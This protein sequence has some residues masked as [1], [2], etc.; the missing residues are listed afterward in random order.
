MP[1]RTY[2]PVPRFTPQPLCIAVTAVPGK[3]GTTTFFM[4]HGTYSISIEL[5]IRRVYILPVTSLGANT[6]LWAVM[7]N[8]HLGT[9]HVPNNR[10][11]HICALT[12]GVPLT[13]D[14][15]HNQK[16]TIEECNFLAGVRNQNPH[17]LW[18]PR[19]L[20][21][22]CRRFQQ[23]RTSSFLCS[24]LHF[25]HSHHN[26]F[27]PYLLW[28]SWGYI[29]TPGMPGLRKPILY[30]VTPTCQQYWGLSPV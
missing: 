6:F 7:K 27:A 17:Q 14:H 11:R 19:R 26:P 25:T 3:A 13:H 15:L 23:L 20:C 2:S 5:I 28:G 30:P 29:R 10:G 12:D 22:A 4:C 8:D 18:L 16:H 9:L 21:T 24:N 1:E